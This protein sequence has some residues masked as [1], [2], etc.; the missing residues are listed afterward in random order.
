M[1]ECLMFFSKVLSEI[2]EVSY[3]YFM[4]WIYVFYGDFYVYG[5]NLFIVEIMYWYWNVNVFY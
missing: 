4:M 1:E 5:W 3:C 2:L